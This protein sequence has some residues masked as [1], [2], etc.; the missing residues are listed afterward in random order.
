MHTPFHKN[1]FQID[2]G[3]IHYFEG[4]ERKFVISTEKT[5]FKA[6]AVVKQLCAAHT[7]EEYFSLLDAGVTPIQILGNKDRGWLLR[8]MKQAKRHIG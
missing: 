5:I 4:H 1:Q 6:Q 7:Q 3:S 2:N 8:Q